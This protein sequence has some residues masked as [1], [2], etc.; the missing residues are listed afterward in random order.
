M[1]AEIPD[2]DIVGLPD[3]DKIG[4]IIGLPE[5]GHLRDNL[6]CF[7]LLTKVLSTCKIS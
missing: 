5:R 4:L 3:L 2:R 1:I 7:A 6:A